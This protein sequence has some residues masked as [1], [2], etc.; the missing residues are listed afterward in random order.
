MIEVTVT[1]RDGVPIRI[2]SIGH[3]GVGVGGESAPCAAVS[4]LLQA[5]GLV[6]IDNGCV[7]HG[8]VDRPGLFDVTVGECVDPRWYRGVADVTVEALRAVQRSWPDEIH[9]VINEE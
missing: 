6:V 2:V 8:T 5:F 9:V 4:T 3:A 1:K 7:I